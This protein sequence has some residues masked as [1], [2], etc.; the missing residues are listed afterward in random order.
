MQE[1]E[2]QKEGERFAETLVSIC[3]RPP[4]DKRSDGRLLHR[5]YGNQAAYV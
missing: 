4:T 3:R 1:I 2:T 5:N